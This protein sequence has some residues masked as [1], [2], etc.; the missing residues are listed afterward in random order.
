MFTPTTRRDC[1][2]SSSALIKRRCRTRWK[3]GDHDV[4]AQLHLLHG[5]SYIYMTSMCK[6]GKIVVATQH[7]APDP[8]TT[9]GI[10]TAIA[11]HLA[12]AMEVEVISGTPGST[13]RQ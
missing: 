5:S 6:A 3:S 13:T 2:K 8:S 9:A 10:M 12:K 1:T 11:T 4:I 7:Y